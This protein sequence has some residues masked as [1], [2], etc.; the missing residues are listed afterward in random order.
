MNPQILLSSEL[1]ESKFYAE[2]NENQSSNIAEPNR[3]LT[4]V[5]FN[6]NSQPTFKYR[7]T[8]KY[9]KD[10]QMQ[11]MLVTRRCQGQ[12]ITRNNVAKG[13]YSSYSH[14]KKVTNQNVDLNYLSQQMSLQ[15]TRNQSGDLNE[16]SEL[17]QNLL[18]ECLNIAQN[19]DT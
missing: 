11:K 6:Q 12:N 16:L 15:Q 18:S 7:T 13:N 4:Q 5:N 14:M 17:K 3:R 8:E 9:D 1:K 19:T 2:N 10:L